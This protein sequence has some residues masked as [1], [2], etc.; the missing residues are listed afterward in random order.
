MNT[1]L[2]KT[3]FENNTVRRAEGKGGRGSMGTM[4]DHLSQ[5]KSTMEMII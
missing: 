2:G 1:H 5:L 3:S 4:Q